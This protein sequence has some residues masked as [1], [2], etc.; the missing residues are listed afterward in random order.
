MGN[1]IKQGLITKPGDDSEQFPQHQ[2]EFMG[3]TQNANKVLPYPLFGNAPEGSLVELFNRL[4]QEENKFSISHRND[5][6]EAKPGEGGIENIL[7][8]QFIYLDE[9][10]NIQT[11]SPESFMIE[12]KNII[13]TVKENITAEFVKAILTGD[14]ELSGNVTMTGDIGVTGN[15][16]A[17]GTIQGDTDVTAG[18]APNKVSL[19]D[20][21]H[22]GVTPG[23]GNTAPPNPIP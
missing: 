13:A 20:H 22:G 10:G 5:R 15:I 18:T 6:K 12:V 7:K 4:C 9:N 1:D 21:D 11:F 2:V 8:G 19:K 16:S 14:I 23:F 17:T 3:N